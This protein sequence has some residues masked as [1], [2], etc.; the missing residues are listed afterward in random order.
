MN[1]IIIAISAL[2]GLSAVVTIAGAVYCA[3]KDV[4]KEWAK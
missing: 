4:E 2:V 1:V 3:L